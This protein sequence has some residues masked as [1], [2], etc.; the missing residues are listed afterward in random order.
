MIK[1]IISK[2][3]NI[4]KW[5]KNNVRVSDLLRKKQSENGVPEGSM[6]KLILDVPTRWN[7]VFYMI[8]RFVE[9][10]TLISPLLIKD[11]TAPV[12]LTAIEMD[13]LK[14]LLDLLKPMEFVTKESSGKNYITI[15]KVIPMISYLQKQLTQIKPYFE[16]ICEIKD[17]LHAELT[18]IFGMIEQVKP[19][20]IATLLDPR[21]KILHFND[22]V[23]CSSAIA[24]LRKLSKLDTISSSES[25]GEHSKTDNFDFWAHHKYLVHGQKKKKTTTFMKDELSFYLSNP[26]S[27]LKSDPLKIWEDMKHVFPILYKQARLHTSPW[28]QHLFLANDFFQRLEQH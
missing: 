17:L 9:M 13:T 19:I 12:M 6:K 7:S 25:E 28:L 18:R 22:P 2:V 20:A 14:Q 8:S 1:P 3:R 26:V 21:F 5:V 16:V 4:V 10:V 23:A 15:S 24:D 27:T 11:Y